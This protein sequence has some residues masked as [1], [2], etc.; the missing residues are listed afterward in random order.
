M[1]V[2]SIA[3][4]SR[5]IDEV[6]AEIA[7]GTTWLRPLQPGEDEPLRAVFAAMSVESRHARYLQGLSTLTPQMTRTLCA[8]DGI[9]HVAWVASVGDRA[10]GIARYIGVGPGSAEIAFEVADDLGGRG[11]GA[12]LVDTVTTIAAAAG[13]RRLLATVLGSNHRS[14]RLLSQVGLELSWQDGGV[15]EGDGPFHLLE[16]PRIDR[17][18]VV[19]LALSDQPLAA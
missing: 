8:V 10:V 12:V 2:F 1:S 15:L 14:R 13:V 3:S 5:R 18:K 19:R 4:P 9:D 16:R 6:P 7:G 11:L 17:S